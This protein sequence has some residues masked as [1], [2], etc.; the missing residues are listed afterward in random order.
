MARSSTLPTDGKLPQL[1]IDCL[2][3][4]TFL[5]C[6]RN[7]HN[8]MLEGLGWICKGKAV[9]QGSLD[10]RGIDGPT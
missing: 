4:V 2:E 3:M 1:P 10:I 9:Q 5:Q 6:L 7:H 8:R